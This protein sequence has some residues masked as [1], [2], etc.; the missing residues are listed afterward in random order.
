MSVKSSSLET[1]F[2]SLEII[3]NRTET[4]WSPDETR[5]KLNELR[6]LITRKEVVS[7]YSQ[8]NEESHYRSLQLGLRKEEVRQLLCTH[9]PVALS[10]AIVEI[11]RV[12]LS[13]SVTIDGK[14]L[15]KISPTASDRFAAIDPADVAGR[16]TALLELFK[17]Y[18]GETFAVPNTTAWTM[19]YCDEWAKKFV[20]TPLSEKMKRCLRTCSQSLY[21]ATLP[22]KEVIQHAPNLPTSSYKLY[23]TV[24]ACGQKIH[25]F[26][27][28][29]GHSRIVLVLPYEMKAFQSMKSFATIVTSYT[30]DFDSSMNITNLT[31]RAARPK[32]R[33]SEDV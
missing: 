14:E 27:F 11:W 19:E 20:A 22:E 5:K 25:R 32:Y 3:S 13:T 16:F 10:T 18:C 21:T 1:S 2:S 4:L 7:I 17:Q 29:E 9:T 6:N 31:C 24:T 23:A 33:H 30:I 12:A 26:F 8:L 28:T 15:Q